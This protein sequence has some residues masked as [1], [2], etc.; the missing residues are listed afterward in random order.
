M[1]KL[2][3]QLSYDTSYYVN[4]LKNNEKF[5]FVRYG[6]GEWLLLLDSGWEEGTHVDKH[7]V[8]PGMVDDLVKA[9]SSDKGYIKATWPWDGKMHRK[10]KDRLERFLLETNPD[11]QWHDAR[12]LEDAA[13]GDR[14]NMS[15]F[16]NQVGKMKTVVI[17]NE[18]KMRWPF[19]WDYYI[20][21]PKKNCYIAKDKIKELILQLSR[22]EE[23]L[24][25][26]FSAGMMTGAVVDDFY[27]LIDVLFLPDFQILNFQTPSSL[28]LAFINFYNI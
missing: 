11:L 14:G 21:I 28:F 25:F 2:K 16:I 1:S 12:V 20:S 26:L 9:M 23:D 10:Y 17:S 7:D 5:S 24:V 6:D 27:P 22:D 4:K 18:D 8:L 13:M 19:P 3:E 15:E